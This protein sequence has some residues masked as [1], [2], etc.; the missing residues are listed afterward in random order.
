MLCPHLTQLW[1]IDDNYAVFGHDGGGIG[2]EPLNPC[3]KCIL[4]DKNIINISI[5]TH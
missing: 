4:Y 3:V 5:K 2:E 1:M